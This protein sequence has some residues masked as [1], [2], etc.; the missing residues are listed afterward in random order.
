[1]P[2]KYGLWRFVY[3]LVK[4]NTPTPLAEPIIQTLNIIQLLS[5]VEHFTSQNSNTKP[6]IQ[7]VKFR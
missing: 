7:K 6:L 5:L 1:M 4:A 3:N 2:K